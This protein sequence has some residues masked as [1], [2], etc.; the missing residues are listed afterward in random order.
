MI[1]DKYYLIIRD[2]FSK[3]RK[4]EIREQQKRHICF[5]CLTP[6]HIFTS[7]LLAKYIYNDCSKILLISDFIENAYDIAE[8]LR[9][10]KVFDYIKVVDE[11]NRN[12]DY[13]YTK[14]IFLKDFKIDVLHFFSWGSKAN[15]L[16]LSYLQPSTKVILTDE[17]LMTYFALE[18]AKEYVKKHNCLILEEF[19]KAQIDEIWLYNP[20]LYSSALKKSLLKIPTLLFVKSEDLKVLSYIFGFDLN[21]KM[22]DFEVF[23]VDQNLSVAEL[24]PLEVEKLLLKTVLSFFSGYNVLI[25]KHPTDSNYIKKYYEIKDANIRILTNNFPFELIIMNLRQENKLVDKIFVTYFSSSVFN[26]YTFTQ[27]E[28]CKIFLLNNII[29]K[30]VGVNKN[31]SNYVN[32]IFLKLSSIYKYIYNP[33]SLI[34]FKRYIDGS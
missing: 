10:F 4:I 31:Y 9:E 3:R 24:M 28:R 14:L 12:D 32:N 27:K 20:V 34:E 7:F 19:L 26:I 25:K 30:I 16:L 8:K 17:G 13:I 11:K 6:F 1:D 29:S 33:E 22:S 23:F 21:I 15:L 2:T 5:S 18:F